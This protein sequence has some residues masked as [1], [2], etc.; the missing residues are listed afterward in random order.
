MGLSDAIQQTLSTAFSSGGGANVAISD[1]LKLNYQ[2]AGMYQNMEQYAGYIQKLSQSIM[3]IKNYPGVMMRSKGQGMN[4][5][6]GSKP[7]AIGRGVI[8]YLD[9]IGQPTWLDI[10]TIQVKCILRG[11]ITGGME[12]TL[13]ESIATISPNAVLPFAASPQRFLSSLP[14]TG[15]VI[16]VLHIGDFRN[17]DGVGWSTTY[18]ILYPGGSGGPYSGAQE[19]SQAVEQSSQ[20]QNPDNQPADT[21]Q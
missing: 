10:A 13:P 5:F 17:P 19:S 12:V 9:L 1:G 6:D 14:G 4:V 7:G 8:E 2:D 16:N 21:S 18:D 3:G 20:N 15:L 11:D